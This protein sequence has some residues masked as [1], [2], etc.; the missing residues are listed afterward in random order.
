MATKIIEAL[1]TICTENLNRTRGGDF[2]C[3]RVTLL[4]IIPSV[5]FWLLIPIFCM[6][7]HRIRVNGG[8]RSQ[9]LPWTVLLIAKTITTIYLLL[10][11]LTSFG[12]NLYYAE[13]TSNDLIYSAVTALTMLGIFCCI[14]MGR[15]NGMV[16]SGILHIT[17]ILFAVCGC[18]EYLF[19]WKK[20]SSFGV[21]FQ[22]MEYADKARFIVYQVWYPFIIV[23]MLLFCFADYRQP[24]LTKARKQLN[25]SSEL[26][27]S[28]LNRLSLWWF[29]PIPLLG[30]RKALIVDDIYQLNEGNNAAIFLLLNHI[31]S[32]S[33]LFTE[34]IALAL[35]MF[36]C[37]ELRSFLLNYYFFLMMRVGIKIQSTLIAA[38]Y[39]KTL[40]L[41]NSARKGRTVG[42]IV[43][44]MAIDVESF[45]FITPHIQQFWSCPFQ[46]I[47]VLIYL[48]FTIGPSAACGVAVMVLFLPLN[49]IT[50]LIVK[51]W[52]TEQMCLKDER[53]KICNEIL[54]GIKV[55]KLYAWEPPM[56]EVVERIRRKELQLIRKMGLTR[57][58]IDSFNTSSPFLVGFY[59]QLITDLLSSD[60]VALL[61][62]ATYTLSSDNHTLTPQIAFVS[63][64]LLNQLRSPMII[65]A[66]L[67]KQA[68]EAAVANGR[69]K[70]FLAADELNPLNIDRINDHFSTENAIEMKE[71]SLS[72]DT[73]GS[74]TVLKIDHLSIPKKSLVAVVGKVGSGKST[75]LSAILGELEKVD[76]YIG[77]FGQMA[78]VSQQSWIQNSTLR[79]NIIFG[80]KFDQKY[81]DKIVE[82]CALV[83]DFDILPNGDATEIGEKG[84]N[85][86]GGQKARV[87]LARAVYQNRDIYLLDDPLSAVDSHVGR[88]I[89]ERVIGCNG[90]MRNKTRIIV[91]NDLTY[92]DK[93]DIVIYMEDGKLAACGPYKKLLEQSES[94]S[95][96]I[97]ACQIENEQAE[98]GKRESETTSSETFSDENSQS[99]DIL[100][101]FQ[102]M[103][104]IKDTS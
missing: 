76:G 46:I 32:G 60:M 98:E 70:S 10:N 83:K 87:A 58:V 43:N 27:S 11:S 96:F 45:Q 15:K 42:E 102:S 51:R 39:Q 74:N 47:L 64:T 55:I 18:P 16:T 3:L 8:I 85:L 48:F 62:F 14:L 44:L 59:S 12:I 38:I 36:A 31:S 13:N 92:L 90:L 25:L 82:A 37:A 52:Q 1:R 94:F 40:R 71:A 9:P 57:A 75:L 17:W 67:M 33:D 53:I 24:F 103:F 19:S 65:I 80:E 34:G 91:T 50:S 63:L 26:D 21:F 2:E 84:I 69:I 100:P 6:Q 49:F 66:N 4:P 79:G 28:F 73:K 41:S 88:H 78:S 56:E 29:T 97:D 5:F 72:W 20:V 81:Y 54:N 86:S 7:I 99:D 30:A 22:L 95:R 77:V 61:T 104:L 93:V 35:G 89:F 23:Q 101:L 68:V